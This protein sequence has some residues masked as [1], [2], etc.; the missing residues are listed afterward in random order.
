M[1][2]LIGHAAIDENGKNIDLEW[3]WDDETRT[4]LFSYESE[5][6]KVTLKGKF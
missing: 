1:S 5:A 4:I 2:V 3:N 6:N